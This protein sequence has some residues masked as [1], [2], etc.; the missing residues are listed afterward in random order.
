MPVKDRKGECIGAM[1]MTV[2]LQTHPAA[3]LVE[4]YLPPLR[5]AARALR[6]IL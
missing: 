3:K 5:E 4:T 1:G 6:P 2:N